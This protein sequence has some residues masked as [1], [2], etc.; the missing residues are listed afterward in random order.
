MAYS[1]NDSGRTA[2][3]DPLGDELA[4]EPDEAEIAPSGRERE[5]LSLGGPLL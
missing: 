1:S 4:G 3:Y 5:L 2:I